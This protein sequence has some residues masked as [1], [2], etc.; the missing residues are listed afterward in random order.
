M[1]MSK[2]EHAKLQESFLSKEEI[3][4]LSELRKLGGL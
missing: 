1:K 4:L 3:A 2:E